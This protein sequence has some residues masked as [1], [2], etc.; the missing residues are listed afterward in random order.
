MK[1]STKYLTV[2]SLLERIRETC[3]KNSLQESSEGSMSVLTINKSIVIYFNH[4]SDEIGIL[5]EHPL[6][7]TKMFFRLKDIDVLVGSYYIEFFENSEKFI[8]V[9]FD[10]YN[11]QKDD[12]MVK[13]KKIQKDTTERKVTTSRRKKE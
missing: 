2:M 9:D 11:I 5:V 1:N 12:K 8:H 7:K 4:Q 6:I 3:K 13:A 10:C